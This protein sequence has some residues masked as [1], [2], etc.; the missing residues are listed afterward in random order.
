MQWILQDIPIG[1]NI[2]HLRMQRNMTQ[3]DLVRKIQLMGSGMSRST[4]GNIEAGIRN[5]K[6][7]DLKAIKMALE[8]EYE[9]FFGERN[10]E[11]QT[12][13]NICR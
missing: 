12:G 13:R 1:K 6:A 4:L 3:L 8:A 2:R 11:K 5:I 9:E 7:S 10:C